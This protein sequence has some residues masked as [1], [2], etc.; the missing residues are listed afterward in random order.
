MIRGCSGSYQVE[1]IFYLS[2]PSD[3]LFSFSASLIHSTLVAES[4][5]SKKIL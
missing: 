3:Y 4:I 1:D 5:A 2:S